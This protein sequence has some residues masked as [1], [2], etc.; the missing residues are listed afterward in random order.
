MAGRVNI[1]YSDLICVKYKGF[2]INYVN[3]ITP[4]DFNGYLADVG[5]EPIVLYKFIEK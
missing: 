3:R 1:I 2:Q 4:Y 5:N